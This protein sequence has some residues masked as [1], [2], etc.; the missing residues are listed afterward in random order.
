MAKRNRIDIIEDILTSIKNKGR[1]R[2]THVMYKS[3]LSHRQMKSYLEE[4][5]E[6]NFIRKVEGKSNNN[7]LTITETGIKFLEKIREMKEFEEA[8]GL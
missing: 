8:F 4:L 2:P 5:L 7:Y 3:N 6:K 1:I